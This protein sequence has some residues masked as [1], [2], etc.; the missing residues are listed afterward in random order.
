MEKLVFTREQSS[1]IHVAE[2]NPTK[3]VLYLSFHNGGRYR[4]DAVPLDVWENFKNA[5]SKGSYFAANIR[6]QYKY[7][8]IY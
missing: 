7:E 8:R 2:Y 3:R 5:P 6:T 1:N 4:Y